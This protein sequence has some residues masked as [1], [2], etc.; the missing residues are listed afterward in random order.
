[1]PKRNR[2]KSSARSKVK[3]ALPRQIEIP[4]WQTELQFLKEL[5]IKEN[6]RSVAAL[7]RR[8]VLDHAR[9]RRKLR[10]HRKLALLSAYLQQVI[11]EAFR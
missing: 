6:E 1:M 7:C 3:E 8:I 11:P 10:K 9:K 2:K 4:V 5:A